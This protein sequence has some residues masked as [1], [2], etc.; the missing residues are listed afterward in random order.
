MRQILVVAHQTAA[1]DDLAKVVSARLAA[2]PCRFTLLVPTTPMRDLAG[3]QGVLGAAAGGGGGVFQP[4]P[5]PDPYMMA[6][7]QLDAGLRRLR[8]LGADAEGEVGLE[9]PVDAVQDIVKRRQFDEVI[10]ST[11][12]RRLS[13]WLHRDLPRQV[14]RK[15]GLPV[16]VV[17]PD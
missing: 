16:T 1:G 11:L 3:G 14:E 15:V 9:D 7:G 13:R 6:R 12:P 10:I 4:K 17:T 8:A 5:G 2:E